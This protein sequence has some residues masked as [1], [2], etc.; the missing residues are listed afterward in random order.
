MTSFSAK[1]LSRFKLYI[2]LKRTIFVM[3]MPLIS[4][5][6]AKN[7]YMYFICGSPLFRFTR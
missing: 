4:S 6:E 2:I 5:R 3:N 7:V 1:N